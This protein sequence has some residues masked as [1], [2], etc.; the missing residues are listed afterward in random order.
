MIGWAAL[1]AA[2]VTAVAAQAQDDLDATIVRTDYG[3]PHVTADSWE[4]VGYGVAYAYA[5]DN[6]CLL[7]EEFVTIRGER[8]LYFGPEGKVL[9]GSNETDNLSSDVFMRAVIDLPRLRAGAGAQGR[10]ANLLAAGYVA[11][12]NRF[13]RDAGTEG[14]PT[15]CRGK[16][17]V[18][19]ITSDDMLRLTEKQMLL[20]SAMPFLPAIA[21]AAPPGMPAQASAMGLPEREDMGV[22]SNGW[23][24]GGEVTEDGRGLVIGNPHFPWQGPNRFWQVHATIPG[25]L[26]VMG[27]T[28]AGGPIPTL[29]FNRDIAWTHTVTEARHFT[30]YQLAL[31]PADPTRYFVDGKPMEMTERTVSVP[32][33]DGAEPVVRTLYSTIYGPLVA[34]PQVGLAWTDTMAFSMRDANS[35]NQRALGTWVRIAQAANVDDVRKAVTETLGIPWVNTIVADRYGNALHADV[36]SVPNVSAEKVAECATP[37]SG[38]VASRLTLLDGAR[39]ACNWTVAK[40]TP[41]PGL[42]P[43][44]EQAIQQRRDSVTNSNDSYWLSNASAPNVQLSPILG[45]WGEPVTLR[46]RANFQETDAVLAIGPLTRER[47]QA[48]AFSNRS[49]AA[50]MVV[51][52]LL[53][54]CDS[55]PAAAPACGVLDGWDRRFETD[56]RGAYLFTTFWDKVRKRPDLW[57]TPFDP[58][59]PVNTPRDLDTQGEAG[60]RLLAAL[61]EAASE[62]EG[63]GIALDAPWGEVQFAPRNGTR[64]AIHGGSGDAGILNVQY[65]DRIEGGVTPVHGT[66]YIQIVGFDEDGPVADA[67]LSYSQSTNPASPHY[68]DQTEAYA[69]KA[70]NRLPFSAEEIEAARQ[71]DV[72]RIAE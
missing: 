32:M 48:L 1:A 3:I 31:D 58:A 19:P 43:A 40:G 70:W 25:K 68:A 69:I 53:F 42:L 55:D 49:L 34:M 8:S 30:L 45:A 10:E 39:S 36:T 6:L 37:F 16:P 71:G 61:V 64:I 62:I 47:A 15:E 26:D 24:F 41:V 66:S 29:G 2:A 20:A 46:T 65:A 7:A 50:E 52:P 14:I 18:K 9:H 5:Q 51:D 11:G 63:R 35:A 17:W 60:T 57:S 56:S 67:I 44:S 28:L 72:L 4:G 33:P 27:S 22:G 59:D 38:L 21:N 12:Y 23:A 54:I 13:L